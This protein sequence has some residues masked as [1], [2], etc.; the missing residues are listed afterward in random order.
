MSNII[1]P[2]Q[3]EAEKV[4]NSNN[5]KTAKIVIVIV[6]VFVTLGSIIVSAYLFI[7][8]KKKEAKLRW[9]LLK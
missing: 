8:K 7:E 3:T 1:K 6:I 2:I 5:S 4:L 9:A